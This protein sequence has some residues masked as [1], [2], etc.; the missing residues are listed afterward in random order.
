MADAPAP[1][2]RLAM[3]TEVRRS[4]PIGESMI[5]VVLGGGEL[6]RFT[7][8]ECTDSYVKLVFL[9]PGVDY[10]RPLDVNA[11][12][13]THA[14]KD[15]PRLRTYTVRGWDPRSHELTLDIVVHGDAGLAG[16]WARNVQPGDEV[17]VVGPGGEYAPDPNADWHLLVGDES[18]LPAICVAVGSLPA[19]AVGHVFLEVDGPECEVA[20]SAPTGVAVNW[21][22]RSG[23]PIG[24]LLVDAVSALDFP[25]GK[26]HAFVHGEAGFVK[27]LRK[28]LR[29]ERGLPR[30]QL[31]ISGYWRYGADDEAWR[32]AK[33]QW[34]REVE[35][36][37]SAAGLA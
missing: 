23:S 20:L 3:L 26:V 18:A 34:N 16:P 15:W 12:K 5:R 17:F 21:L 35:E 10:P 29:I 28:L 2:A 30:E 33:R 24:Q 7:A 4:E 22:H 1:R 11:V 27:E 9:S 19:D 36:V 14:A 8:S 13:A 6:E 37:E 31:S 25:S 32:A